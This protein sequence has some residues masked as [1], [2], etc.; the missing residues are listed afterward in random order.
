MFEISH[1]RHPY[2][3]GNIGGCP[4]RQHLEGKTQI[5]TYSNKIVYPE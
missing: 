2:A 4:E 1:Q 3:L 5:L